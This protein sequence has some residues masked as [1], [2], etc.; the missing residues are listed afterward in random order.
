MPSPSRLAADIVEPVQ[1][2]WV[3]DPCRCRSY[4]RVTLVVNQI[5]GKHVFDLECTQIVV[6][7]TLRSSM[8]R[9][10]WEGTNNSHDVI[11]AVQC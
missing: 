8:S 9:K 3:S 11:T 10:K 5:A 4:I 7:C 2:Q 6:H 1:P